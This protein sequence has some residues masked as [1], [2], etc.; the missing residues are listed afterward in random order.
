METFQQKVCVIKR[1][2]KFHKHVT[3]FR[4]L[5]GLH[6]YTVPP[7]PSVLADG[8]ARPYHVCVLQCAVCIVSVVALCSAV[9]LFCSL[10]H[11]AEFKTV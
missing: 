10:K 7:V 4:Q 5:T 3:M 8:A 11:G 2:M 6:R 1:D 9:S